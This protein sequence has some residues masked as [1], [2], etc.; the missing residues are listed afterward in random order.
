MMISGRK[1]KISNSS[2]VGESFLFIEQ[3]KTPEKAFL[4]PWKMISRQI[5]IIIIIKNMLFVRMMKLKFKLQ[6]DIW[7]WF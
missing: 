1:K 2:N 3:N 5:K 6:F 4:G 7:D